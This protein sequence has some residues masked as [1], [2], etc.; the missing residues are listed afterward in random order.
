[1]IFNSFFFSWME[2]IFNDYF[3]YFRSATGRICEA[4][5]VSQILRMLPTQ[6][7]QHC[8]LAVLIEQVIFS[9]SYWLSV[10]YMRI[11]QNGTLVS[12]GWRR[13]QGK[14][15]HEIHAVL[16]DIMQLKIGSKLMSLAFFDYT[17]VTCYWFFEIII[18]FSCDVLHLYSSLA[19][20]AQV[21]NKLCIILI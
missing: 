16:S 11:E 17:I 4:A 18:N 21:R 13:I 19:R 2:I 9:I 8:E 7:K 15:E 1:M 10:N 5:K 12:V 6:Q 14:I 3:K 20:L